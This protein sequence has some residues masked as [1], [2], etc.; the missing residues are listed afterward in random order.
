MSSSTKLEQRVSQGSKPMILESK[1][2]IR[3]MD[4]A[5]GSAIYLG[6]LGSC[7]AL[8]ALFLGASTASSGEPLAASWYRHLTFFMWCLL[9]LMSSAARA[10]LHARTTVWRARVAPNAVVLSATRA[11]WYTLS[12]MGTVTVL[13]L[14]VMIGLAPPLSGAGSATLLVLGLMGGSLSATAVAGAAWRGQLPAVWTLPGLLL[15]LGS[16][17]LFFSESQWSQWQ[18][19]DGFRTAVLV[20][21][22]ASPAA[23]A[24]LL[25]STL[26]VP[27]EARTGEQKVVLRAV[28]AQGFRCLF[29]RLRYV[30]DVAWIGIASAGWGM[31]IQ[32]YVFGQVSGLWAI[33]WGSNFT[34]ADPWWLVWLTMQVSFLLSTPALHWRHLLAPNGTLRRRLGLSIWLTTYLTVVGTLALVFGIL[35]IGLL[36]LVSGGLERWPQMP[37]LVLRNASVLLLDLALATAL[38]TLIRG[39]A[40]SHGRALLAL[41]TLALVWGL[42]HLLIYAWTGQAMTVLLQRDTTYL[43]LLL[44][45]T[46][47]CAWAAARAWSR[48][49]LGALLRSSTQ[50]SDDD[51]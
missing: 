29:E 9:L 6:F 35:G 26:V 8:V 33:G 31:L 18:A 16:L 23:T 7:A 15:L 28:V 44:I 40:G 36:A 5:S 3:W 42:F 11:F 32:G 19:G 51:I 43:L 34:T 41:I 21:L 20:A 1:P 47:G 37:E 45:T 27:S 25:R 30:N 50:R 10:A 48:A 2:G 14:L 38:A 46:S 49:D 39:W 24:A 12:R 4:Q 13:P 17:V 22:A